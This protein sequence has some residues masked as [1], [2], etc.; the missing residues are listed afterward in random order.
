[1]TDKFKFD[2]FL[3]HNHADKPKVKRLAEKLRDAGV[4]VW[5]DDWAILPGDIISLMVDEGLEQSRV[6]LL[7]VSPNAL[8]SGWVALER[9]TAIHRDPSN[10]GRRFI[11]LLLADCEM[12]DTLRRYKFIDYRE[13]TDASFEELL[14]ACRPEMKVETLT[15]QEKPEKKKPLSEKPLELPEPLAVQEREIKGHTKWVRSL[16]VSPNGEWIASGSW[17]NTIKIWDIES[18]ECRTTLVGHSNYVD[19]VAITPDGSRIFSGSNDNS[20]REWN[21]ISGKPLAKLDGHSDQFRSVVALNDN[22]HILSGGFDQSIRVWDINSGLC[23]RTILCGTDNSYDV[24]GLAVNLEGT[25]VI[26]GHRNGESR[27]WNLENGECLTILKGHSDIVNSVQ[28]TPDGLLAVS[29][30]HDKTI[31]VWNLEKGTCIGTMEGHENKIHSIA[32]SPNG[33]FIASTGFQDDT[34]R[35]WDLKT[36]NCL[37]VIKHDILC[38][39]VSITF[40]PDGL[41]LLVGT[42]DGKIYIYRLA[43]TIAFT[44]AETGKRYMNAKVVL[45]G[46]STVGKTTLAHRLIEDQYVQ[47]DSTHGMNVWR[48]EL[49]LPPDETMEREALLWD[50]AGQMGYREIHQIYL[51]QT[52]LALLLIN[53]QKNDPFEEAKDW[54]KALNAAI[55]GQDSKR[56]AAKLLITTRQDVGGITVSE[57]KIRRFLTEHDIRDWLATSAKTGENCSDQ[58]NGNQPSQLKQLSADNIP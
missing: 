38:T 4:K 34:S 7:C 33:L 18:G 46:E 40:S 1:M 16:A 35:L 50:L 24:F 22:I 14:T 31:K 32:I 57:K 11:P 21:T 58:V 39:P 3:S 45:I 42:T 37:Q 12:P 53:P 20:L 23:I 47:T 5:F 55:R 56:R 9:S 2:L 54:L 13:E 27:I 41:R 6:L 19:S 30:S 25:K 28:I 29:G 48:L 52:S 43:G 8:S 15:L 44:S 26:S 36:G 17:D 10:E 51:D 49:P